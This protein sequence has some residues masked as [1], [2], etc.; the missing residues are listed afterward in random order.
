MYMYSVYT[1]YLEP[2]TGLS[3]PHSRYVD[4]SLSSECRPVEK[5]WREGE[6]E[7]EGEREK[8]EILIKHTIHVCSH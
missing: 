5:G 3:T 2:S 1:M 4:R 8:Q 6:E 7:G